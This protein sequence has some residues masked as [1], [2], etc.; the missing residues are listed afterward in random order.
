MKPPLPDP[1]PE[2]S[3]TAPLRFKLYGDTERFSSGRTG[4]KISDTTADVSDADGNKVGYIAALIGGGVEVTFYNGH[5]PNSLRSW[6]VSYQDL[7]ALAVE[8]DES[9]RAEG[10]IP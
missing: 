2:A 7:W 10:K 8:A 5:D 3:A 1:P 4:F 6:F 9:Y